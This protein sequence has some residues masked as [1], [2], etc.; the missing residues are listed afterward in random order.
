[1]TVTV[2]PYRPADYAAFRALRD[3]T[4]PAG[5]EPSN[6]EPWSEQLDDIEGNF[7]AFWVAVD[8][9]GG[10]EEV[11]GSAG[12]TE[13]GAVDFPPPAPDF[14]DETERTCRLHEMRAAPERQ[15][16]G[17]G[18]LLLD[19][20][21][22]WARAQGYEA[23]CFDTTAQQI[24]AIEFYRA[25]GFEERGRSMYLGRWELIWFWLAL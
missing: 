13:G 16:Q 6:P 22:A 2:R 25:A 14:I 21:L 12:L 18:T 11:V 24:A 23:M 20:V 9:A 3:R 10:G 7:V 19:E 15:R 8:D 1:M 5:S 17:I 4:P